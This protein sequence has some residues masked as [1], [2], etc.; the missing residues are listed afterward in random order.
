VATNSLPPIPREQIGE[1]YSW[2][3]WFNKLGTYIQ[4][5]QTGGNAWTIIQGGTGATTADGARSNL[6]IGSIGTQ[7]YNNVAITGGSLDSVNITSSAVSGTVSLTNTTSTTVG[8]AGTASAL[9]SLPV[10]YVVINI[11]GTN[12]KLPY[13]NI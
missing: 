12:Y 5:A 2:R 8:A 3:D 9:P 6:G 7:N 11:G 1:V 4:T 13:Y 10:G